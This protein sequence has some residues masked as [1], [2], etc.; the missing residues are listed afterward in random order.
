MKQ[1]AILI[2]CL[3]LAN[4]AKVETASIANFQNNSDKTAAPTPSAEKETVLKPVEPNIKFTAKQQKYLDE[5][6]PLKVREILEK[7]EKFEVL[8]EVRGENEKDEDHWSVQPNRIIKIPDENSKKEI[9]EA[10]YFDASEEDSPAVCYEPHHLIRANYQ[11]KTVEVEICFGCSRFTVK[12]EFGKFDGTIVRENRKSE[13]LF[14]EIIKTKSI[15][16]KK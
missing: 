1:I 14:D 6:L 3:A 9:L 8:A 2:F 15:E 4:C 5:S 10:F 16:L 7:S 11:G 13:E 12:S